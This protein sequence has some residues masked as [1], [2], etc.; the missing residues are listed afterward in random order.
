MPQVGERRSGATETVEWNGSRWTP[1]QAPA[2][3]APEEGVL[4]R[5]F[6]GA[7]NTSPLNP[8]NL[9][10]AA[11]DI[12]GTMRH[13][14]EDPLANLLKAGGDIK[15]TVTGERPEGRL[16]SALNAAKHIGG[17][18]PLIGPSAIDAGEKIGEGDIAG[19]AG[20][21]AG[22][23]SGA[24]VP[25]VAGRAPKGVQALGRGMEATGN[26]LKNKGSV[27]V[28][29][30]H[31]PVGTLLGTAEAAMGHGPMGLA[32]AAAPYALEYGGKGVTAA[33]EAL[34]G[35]KNLRTP[36]PANRFKTLRPNSEVPYKAPTDIPEYTGE[37]APQTPQTYSAEAELDNPQ[38][39]AF[40]ESEFSEN[41]PI[42]DEAFGA[43]KDLLGRKKPNYSLDALKKWSGYG[44]PDIVPPDF[45]FEGEAN[46]RPGEFAPGPA[47]PGFEINGPTGAPEPS[48]VYDLG[49]S[50][51]LQQL[52][53][54]PSFAGL[55]RLGRR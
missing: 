4:S 2:Q 40:R 11:S 39:Q 43:D 49:D 20:E 37:L 27:N 34:E 1:V 55:S 18:V 6:G 15:A 14:I 9:V 25:E 24:L 26:F 19:G 30:M 38:S 51:A 8:M 22:L 33:G 28:G 31:I 17:S 41:K 21:L 36:K 3:T 53:S 45:S 42:A 7:M 48:G 12:P 32:T 13:I 16:I 44:E 35:L 5:F 47:A 10:R 29:G 52:L 54:S 50:G 46:L 23:A